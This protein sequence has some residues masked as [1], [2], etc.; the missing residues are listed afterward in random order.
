MS[1]VRKRSALRS[2]NRK[3]P[4]L[5]NE[6]LDMNDVTSNIAS[7]INICMNCEKT[8]SPNIFFWLTAKY[9]MEYIYMYLEMEDSID[10]SLAL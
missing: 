6:Y 5:T 7:K 1:Q 2:S 10:L 3:A 4:L 8:Q 9:T